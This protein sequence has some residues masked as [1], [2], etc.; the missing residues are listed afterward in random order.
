MFS[1]TMMPVGSD[2]ADTRPGDLRTL[3]DDELLARFFQQQ[4]DAAFSALV[5]RYGPLVYNVCRRILGDSPDAEDAFQATFLVLVRKGA[6]LRDPGRLANWLYGVAY[7]SARKAKAQAALRARSELRAG[8][9]SS[10]LKVQDMTYEE[11]HAILDE[12]ISQLPEK[13]ALPLVLCY[14]EGKT[15]AQA[16]AAL[17]WPEGSMSR[18]LSRAR[19]LLRSRLARRG[20]TLSA[21][22]LAA[23]L[24]RPAV[25]SVP[26]E[27]VASTVRAG[28]LVARG[29][30]VT[31]VV[32]SVTARVVEEV[33]LGMS[34]LS[35]VSVPAAVALGVLLTAGAAGLWHWG[36]A[37][38]AAS[39][40]PVSMQRP[41][42]VHAL[43]REEVD[44]VITPVRAVSAAGAP[45]S[46]GCS[47][48]CSSP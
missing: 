28:S 12:E 33:L 32:S 26:G 9:P 14:L 42:P 29:T 11:L 30:A 31:E 37:A 4:E 38:Q 18:R 41:S 34:V 1:K 24:A 3:R 17:G 6:S 5:E 48:G 8:I 2:S 13:Y 47:S 22:L 39:R 27:L 21:A 35:R 15:N 43:T 7:R 40:S 16:A 23:S 36:A 10:S 46:V 19:E 44:P 25:A 20:L 45:A